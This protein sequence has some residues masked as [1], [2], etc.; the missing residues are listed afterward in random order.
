M[1]LKK[2]NAQCLESLF[3]KANWARNTL[4]KTASCILSEI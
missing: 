2:G 1:M 3:P 4:A